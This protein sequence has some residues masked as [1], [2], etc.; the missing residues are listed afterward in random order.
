MMRWRCTASGFWLL[1]SAESFHLFTTN[2]ALRQIFLS[3]CKVE[4][5]EV[6]WVLALGYSYLRDSP[7]FQRPLCKFMRCPE[8]YSIE[9]NI[10]LLSTSKEASSVHSDGTLTPP[11]SQHLAAFTHLPTIAETTERAANF[12][13]GSEKYPAEKTSPVSSGPEHTSWLHSFLVSTHIAAP[14]RRMGAGL[15]GFGP[16][17][18]PRS[19]STY[20]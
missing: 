14:N 15:G 1:D 18:E 6:Q 9:A 8:D 20:V 10:H 2:I 11:P 5:E 16:L 3:Q 17:Q 12:A 13:E 7:E 4:V 19:Y